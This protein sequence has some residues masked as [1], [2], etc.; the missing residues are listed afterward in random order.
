MASLNQFDIDDAI[1]AVAMSI[2]KHSFDGCDLCC[3]NG[4]AGLLRLTV[5]T[6]FRLA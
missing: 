5:L 4:T 1:A 6:L 2:L 3:H